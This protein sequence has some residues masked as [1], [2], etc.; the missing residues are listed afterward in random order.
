MAGFI[1]R[2]NAKTGPRPGR[3]D[4]AEERSSLLLGQLARLRARAEAESV[5]EPPPPPAGP[6]VQHAEEA[7]SAP[8]RIAA[9]WSWRLLAIGLAVV[10]LGY[11]M[12]YFSHVTVPLS[13]A[14]LLTALL[15]PMVG[16][17]VAW[18][19]PRWLAVALSMLAMV[20]V[21][22]GA[23]TLIGNQVAGQAPDLWDRALAGF[24][25]LLGWLNSGPLPV[26]QDQ[27]D[28]YLK[29]LREAIS[30]SQSQ[31]ASSAAQVGTGVGAFFA[32]LAIALFSTFF[33]LL[34]GRKLWQALVSGFPWRGRAR[35]SYAAQRGWKALVSY[36]RATILVALFDA[37]FITIG[38]LILGVP[39]AAAI[40]TLVFFGAFVPL[41]GAF[42]SGLVAVLVALVTL[43]WVKALIMLAIITAVMQIEGHILQ[44]LLLGKAVSIHPLVV[45]LGIALGTIVAGIT[46]A[47]FAI[48]LVA[49][50]NA[51]I[52]AAR[53]TG[54]GATSAEP[55]TPPTASLGNP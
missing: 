10:G 13:I 18:G 7:V 40:G 30:T 8:V 14:I 35:A 26:S 9:A 24:S 27:L 20:V 44:P 54:S 19:L 45:L 38:A 34:D 23:F 32:G 6:P 17:L 46:G 2:R 29:Q 3:A 36:V 47:L 43:G 16:R 25:S 11:V 49:F 51:F 50:G 4:G 48:P 39:L 31:I 41:L 55:L 1:P 37:V 22:V 15:S 5:T 53:E 52:R 21:V 42:V 12:R 28:G 33:F